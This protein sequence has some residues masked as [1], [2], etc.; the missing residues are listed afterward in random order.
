MNG[1]SESLRAMPGLI[2]PVIP[3][4]F[5]EP[6]RCILVEDSKEILNENLIRLPGY[7]SIY[8]S[9]NRHR[10]GDVTCTVI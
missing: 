7:I 9:V 3:N 2:I 1:D 4:S 6:L 8:M 10:R 5:Y